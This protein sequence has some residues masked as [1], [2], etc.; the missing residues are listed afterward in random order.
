MTI[1]QVDHQH[2]IL[3]QI[4]LFNKADSLGGSLRRQILPAI[5]QGFQIAR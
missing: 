3:T 2:L 4:G 5:V 1:G